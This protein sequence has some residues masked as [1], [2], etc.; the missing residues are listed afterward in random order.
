MRYRRRKKKTSGEA[1]YHARKRALE[2]YQF[3]LGVSEYDELVGRIRNQKAE[4][5]YRESAT[6]TIW[7]LEHRQRTIYAV[8]QTKIGILTFLT[9]DM[10]ACQRWN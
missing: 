7:R 1:Y 6:R 8:Y 3:E 10:V 2:R 9:E 5:I 4:L